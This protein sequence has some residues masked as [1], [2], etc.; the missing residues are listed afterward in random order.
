[1]WWELGVLLK[2]YSTHYADFV[3]FAYIL[4]FWMG[5]Y[6]VAW[7]PGHVI[8]NHVKIALE[9][10]GLIAVPLNFSSS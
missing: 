7:L 6:T 2:H 1:M 10:L 4:G 9:G 3:F 8:S 5:G